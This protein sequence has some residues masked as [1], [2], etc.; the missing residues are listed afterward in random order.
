VTLALV[1]SFLASLP[2]EGA[3]ASLISGG[4]RRISGGLKRQR[5][6]RGLVVAQVAVSVVLLA[7]AGLLT[8][9]MM[10]LSQVNTGLR[11]EQVLMMDVPLLELS[12]VRPADAAAKERADRMLRGAA[13]PV[14]RRCQ[15]LSMLRRSSQLKS[16]GR[17][18]S[19]GRRRRGQ[20]RTANPDTGG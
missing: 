4:G 13:V 2:R 17:R 8:R 6:Q 1:L 15:G 18:R 19:S 3:F 5:L 9:T 7:G 16:G 11:T 10:Q 20:S 14:S 12:H